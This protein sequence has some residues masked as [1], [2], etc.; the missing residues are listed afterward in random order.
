MAPPAPIE[1][2]RRD[3]RRLALRAQL[4]TAD[5]PAT[6]IEAARE[7]GVIQVDHTPYVAPNAELVLWSRLG[8]AATRGEIWDA[9]DERELIELHGFLRPAEDIALF[10]AEMAAWPG[11]E[12][13]EYRQW[14]AEWA[15]DN[16]LAQEQVIEQLR[17]EGPLPARAL[18]AEFHRDWRSSGW[19][20]VKNV[21]MLMERLNDVG[22]VA[23]SHREGRER[24]WDVADRVYPDS[25][26]V[27]L[28]EALHEQRV[29]R[30]RRMGL[31][32]SRAP[33]CSGEPVDI[34][35][36]GI[37]VRVAGVRGEWRADPE[38]LERRFSGR[39]ALLSPLDRLVFDRKRMAELFEFDYALEM[40]KP[41][42]ARRWGYFALPVLHLDQ[43]IG[44]VDAE[45][46]RTEGALVVHAIH[47]DQPWS[48]SARRAVRA[49]LRSLA[50]FLD[51]E[52][53]PPQA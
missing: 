42:A 49:E 11:P 50:A 30:L 1:L 33:E 3:A 45:A 40:Y 53:V 52:L 20:N 24:I 8:S 7:L 48:T 26:S 47:E 43:L 31:T 2:S 29:R 10:T 32:R 18:H 34:G 44:K 15:D 12:P 51:L 28:E 13:S 36:V 21:T 16:R 38:L 14:L 9:I 35:D 6:L 23:V 19:N 46:M 27:P 22:K 5:R 17:A 41:A 39:T 37:P 4:L 25:P